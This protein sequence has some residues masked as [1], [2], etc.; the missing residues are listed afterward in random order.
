MK[1]SYDTDVNGL[2]MFKEM[3]DYRM[4]FKTRA[5]IEL[6]TPEDLLRFMV[7]NEDNAYPNLR[8]GCRILPPVATTIASCKLPSSKLKHV[9]PKIIHWT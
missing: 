1:S 4:L 2:E 7:Q 9:V 3:I 6:E 8:V 5:D